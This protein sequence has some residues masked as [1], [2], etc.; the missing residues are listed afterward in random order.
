MKAL[1]IVAALLLAAAAAAA[2]P[3][4]PAEKRGREIYL[5]GQGT[6]KPMTAYFGADGAGEISASVVPCASCH[7]A[8]GRGVPEGTVAPSDI[9]SVS[10]TYGERSATPPITLSLVLSVSG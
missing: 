3:L 10:N 5:H 8:D 6:G 4:T 9:R 2:E 1:V 7:G